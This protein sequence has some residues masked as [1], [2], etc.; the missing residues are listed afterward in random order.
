M[1][2][3]AQ[4]K[5]TQSSKGMKTSTNTEERSHPEEHTAVSFSQG[6]GAGGESHACRLGSSACLG[7]G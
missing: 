3:G 7:E 1:Q 5:Q 6:P 4:S 2:R